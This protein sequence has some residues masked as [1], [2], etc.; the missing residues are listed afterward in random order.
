MIIIS[1]LFCFIMRIMEYFS[2]H[3][4]SLSLILQQWLRWEEFIIMIIG[5]IVTIRMTL[6]YIIP[7]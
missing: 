3:K 5:I 1:N 4:S 7:Y 6:I 2:K